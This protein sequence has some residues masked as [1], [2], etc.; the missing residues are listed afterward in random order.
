MQVLQ[1]SFR[2]CPFFR[3]MCL[4]LTFYPNSQGVLEPLG[5]QSYPYLLDKEARPEGSQQLALGQR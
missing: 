3:Q 4:K 2:F 1:A 5:D